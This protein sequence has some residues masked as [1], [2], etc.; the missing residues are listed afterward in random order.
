MQQSS[1][2]NSEND[3]A[4]SPSAFS[5][6]SKDG[7]IKRPNS[8]KRDSGYDSPATYGNLLMFNFDDIPSRTSDDHPLQES[9]ESSG[10]FDLEDQV[11]T[12]DTSDQEVE[13]VL[14]NPN[15]PGIGP[16]MPVPTRPSA[17]FPSANDREME[18][19]LIQ[20]INNDTETRQCI[21]SPSIHRSMS[22]HRNRSRRQGCYFRPIVNRSVGTQTP[23]PTCQIV[24]DVIERFHP[25]GGN[26][27]GKLLL[28]YILHYKCCQIDD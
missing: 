3:G 28:H 15:S 22:F 1:K 2:G 4:E 5:M 24:H 13:M 8:G 16:S 23:N 12:G 17:P 26:I 11:S 19:D 14:S 9:F 10:A 20:G 25:Y 7:K 18:L 6:C 27:R 21:S